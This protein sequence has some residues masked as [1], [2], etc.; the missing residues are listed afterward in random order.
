MNDNKT[1]SMLQR[2]PAILAVTAASY[3]LPLPAHAAQVRGASS[4]TVTHPA[5]ATQS[6]PQARLTKQR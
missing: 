6:A 5:A 1:R 3:G 4:Y 2:I